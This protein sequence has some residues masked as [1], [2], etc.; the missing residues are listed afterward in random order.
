MN[1]LDKW[2]EPRLESGIAHAADFCARIVVT[3]NS[4]LPLRADHTMLYSSFSMQVHEHATHTYAYA[5][6]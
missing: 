3:F 6:A 1:E 2:F 4:H 5:R